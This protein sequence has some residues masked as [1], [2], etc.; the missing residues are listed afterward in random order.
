MANYFIV[1]GSTGIGLALSHILLAQ[2]HSVWASYHKNPIEAQPAL[3]PI[4]FN[5]LEQQPGWETILPDMLDG[6]AYCPGSIKLLPF[7]RIQSADFIH[8]YELQVLGAVRVLQTLFPRLKKSAHPAVVLFSTVAAQTG[9]P[10]HSLVATHKG[11]VEGLTRALAAEWA[12]AIRV[13]AIAPSLTDTPLAASLLNTP[14]KQTAAAQR[15]PMKRIATA[16]DMARSAAFLLT[17]DSSFITGQIL[18]VDG[19]MSSIR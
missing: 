17:P 2:G 7:G 13:N 9:M 8:D 19:G 10:F 16:N 11:A 5:V 1:G 3:T 14:E 18:P 4:D 15:H 12:P 6:I